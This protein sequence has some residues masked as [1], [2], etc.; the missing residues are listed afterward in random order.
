MT[1][2]GFERKA[3][4]GER[5]GGLGP[6]GFRFDPATKILVRDPQEATTARVSSSPTQTRTSAPQGRLPA[7][8][9]PCSVTAEIGSGAIRPSCV[10]STTWST[11]ARSPTV[12]SSM[13]ARIRRSS[14]TNYSHG[15]S[16]EQLRTWRES[17]PRRSPSL[18][19][20]PTTQVRKAF[21]PLFISF[22]DR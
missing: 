6:Y 3:A 13:M 22:R 17:N 18:Y 20:R 1:S 21:E 14:R 12:T 16:L 19:R 4:R 2:G 5:F 10:C 11:L 8:M 15:P 7:S 9:G